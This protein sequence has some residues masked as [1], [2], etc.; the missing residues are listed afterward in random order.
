MKDTNP[1]PRKWTNS[2]QD[3]FKEIYINMY[4]NKIFKSIEQRKTWKLP[5]R[6]DASL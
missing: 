6:T 4:I 5:E 3:R 2:T 1:D